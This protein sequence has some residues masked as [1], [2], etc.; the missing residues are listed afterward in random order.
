M[1]LNF[2]PSIG[3]LD[4]EGRL[5]HAIGYNGHGVAQ[6]TAVGDLLADLITG[7]ENEWAGT[8]ARPAP[9]LP[10]E[11]FL[12]LVAKGALGFF[13]TLDRIT[14]RQIRAGRF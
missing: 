3:P 13:G 6:A 11:P 1:T 8:I 7:R 12:W 14:D 4:A 9:T 2:L 10:P 5:L